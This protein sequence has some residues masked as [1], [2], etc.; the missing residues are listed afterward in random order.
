MKKLAYEGKRK[1]RIL[2]FWNIEHFE[3]QP[4]KLDA[5]KSIGGLGASCTA[6]FLRAQKE[7][8][9]EYGV[10]LAKAAKMN[11]ALPEASKKKVYSHDMPKSLREKLFIE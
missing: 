2:D 6:R 9:K 3:H 5:R 1:D 10:E 7:L 8:E 4:L 11:E